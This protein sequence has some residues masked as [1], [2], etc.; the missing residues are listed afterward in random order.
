MHVPPRICGDVFGLMNSLHVPERCV[1][2]SACG[3]LTPWLTGAGARRAEGTDT[4]H[5]NAEGMACV[6]IRVERPVS[7]CL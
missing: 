6:G 4:G 7:P 1:E 2:P 3:S 5:E